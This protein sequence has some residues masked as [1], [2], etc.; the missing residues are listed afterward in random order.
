GRDDCSLG[1]DRRP[2]GQALEPVGERRPELDVEAFNGAQDPGNV[3]R[4]C[5]PVLAA[6]QIRLR[7][8]G[9]LEVAELCVQRVARLAAADGVVSA[10]EPAV[11]ALEPERPQRALRG[12]GRSECRRWRAYLA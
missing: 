4:V 9:L 8:E 2:G 6:G 3:A 10:A 1:G 12:F 7:L 5:E 11:E